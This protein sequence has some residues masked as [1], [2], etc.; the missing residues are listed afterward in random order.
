M[1]WMW[2]GEPISICRNF[3]CLRSGWNNALLIEPFARVFVLFD[4]L[5][6]IAPQITI[7]R[8]S[9]AYIVNWY[10]NLLVWRWES[11]CRTLNTSAGISRSADRV[12]IEAGNAGTIS[13]NYLSGCASSNR[14]PDLMP[15]N[16]N[17]KVN[18]T[19]TEMSELYCYD[20][21]VVW[22][23]HDPQYLINYQG[24]YVLSVARPQILAG[25]WWTPRSFNIWNFVWQMGIL[26]S[27][28]S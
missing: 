15:P 24:A 23:T 18:E 4:R 12:V 9:Q 6:Q 3:S 14:S 7:R 5:R 19:V 13:L 26:T 2:V 28:E 25:G 1:R 10:S 22:L 11:Y 20:L 21:L 27:G 8:T 17:R 16:Y